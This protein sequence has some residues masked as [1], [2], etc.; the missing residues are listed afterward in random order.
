MTNPAESTPLR[1][2][3]NALGEYLKEYPDETPI[4]LFIDDKVGIP[5]ELNVAKVTIVDLD[6]SKRVEI[7]LGIVGRWIEK[8][9]KYAG[10]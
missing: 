8:E 3:Y 10:D 5:V 9:V 1:E 6:D 4:L 7:V 2:F